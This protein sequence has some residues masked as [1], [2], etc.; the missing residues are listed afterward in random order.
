MTNEHCTLRCAESGR[1]RLPGEGRC[2]RSEGGE[3]G[4]MRARAGQVLL[5]RVMAELRGSVLRR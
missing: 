5:S 4:V 3:S 2:I 1:D